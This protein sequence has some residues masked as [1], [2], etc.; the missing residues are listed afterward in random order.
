MAEVRR[1][2]LRLLGVAA[3]LTLW[4]APVPAVATE[5][6]AAPVTVPALADWAPGGR[7]PRR[8]SPLGG[9]RERA[10]RAEPVAGGYRLVGAVTRMT[11][12][13]SDGGRLVQ[14]PPGQRP[15]A[16]WQLTAR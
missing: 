6:A 15:P 4:V 12:S 8:R 2:V 9:A 10:G 13:P 14:Y 16:V 5:V 11:V 3:A 7:R 1:R